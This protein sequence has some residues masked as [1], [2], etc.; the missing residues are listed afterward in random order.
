M[1]GST[2]DSSSAAPGRR[3]WPLWL[4]DGEHGVWR[5]AAAALLVLLGAAFAQWLLV[6]AQLTRISLILL[7]SVVMTATWLGARPAFFAAA[8]SFVVY[9]V[10]LSQ[11][12]LR[13]RVDSTDQLITLTL[14]MTAALLTGSLAGRMRDAGRRTALLAARNKALFLAS[15]AMSETEDEVDIRAV[16]LAHVGALAGAPATW[17]APQDRRAWRVNQMRTDA[18]HSEALY[19]RTTGPLNADEEGDLVS[20]VQLMADLAAAAIARARAAANRAKLESIAQTERLQAALLSSISHDFRTPLSAILTSASSLRT[21]DAQFDT[22][23]R[24]DL[25]LTIEEETERLNRFVAKLLQITRL[26]AGALR[27]EIA[28]FDV[29]ATAEAVTRRLCGAGHEARVRME[30]PAPLKAA[31]DQLLFEHA[32]SNVIEN[33]LRFSGHAPIVVRGV[34]EGGCI[35]LTVQDR[36]RGVPEAELGAIFDRFYCASNN[37]VRRQNSGLG[38]SIARGLMSAMAGAISARSGA[39]GVGLCV[40]LTLPAAA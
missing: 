34:K 30:L 8:L 16:L 31:G 13:A 37:D 15:R 4:V 10:M 3:E 40:R 14:F 23:T 28:P 22:A 18:A 19:W 24:R 36:G 21:F 1:R 7:M 6:T 32:L 2:I 5:Y 17:D 20:A 33:A 27:P 35:A 26:E 25:C 12:D 39:D 9:R 11:P 38:L 29:R